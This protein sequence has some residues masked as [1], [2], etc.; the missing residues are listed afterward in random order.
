VLVLIE[1]P[2]LTTSRTGS[3]R[4]R[5]NLGGNAAVED[6]ELSVEDWNLGRDLQTVVAA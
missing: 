1:S 4:G 3:L 5:K 6:S 2:W